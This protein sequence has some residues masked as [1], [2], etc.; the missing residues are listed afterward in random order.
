M[1]LARQHP[2]RQARVAQTLRELGLDLAKQLALIALRAPQG[3]LQ[4]PVAERIQRFEP[5][6]LELDLERI[7]TEPIR[8]RRVD[9]E[10]LARDSPLFVNRERADG[11]HVVRTV[12][13][14]HENHPQILRHRE[15]HFAEAL[16]LRLGRA[17]ES[18]V[19]DLADAVDEQ[20][21]VVAETALDVRERARRIFEHV[22]QQCRL[23]RAGVEV[24]AREDLRDRDR[25]GDVGLA[26]AAQL[27]F[28][29][30]R[31]V[32]VGRG[33]AGKIG[34][35]KVGLELR[36]EPPEVIGAPYRRQPDFAE[37]G[38]IVHGVSVY[39]GARPAPRFVA[40]SPI[41]IGLE[42][43]RSSRSG[44]TGGADER[45]TSRSSTG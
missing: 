45:S 29:R 42:P 12:G 5:E 10:R 20:R 30:L 15:Q 23:D 35:R 41:E 4:D 11:A 40:Q 16:G 38:T 31:A 2:R 37:G 34:A 14:L 27:A 8:D 39:A 1:L 9:V 6:L 22:V 25:M 13:E 18:Q 28:V 17:V 21:D 36:H 43:N 32:L 3:A 24:Q 26:A 7:D 44:M 19:V 33:Y